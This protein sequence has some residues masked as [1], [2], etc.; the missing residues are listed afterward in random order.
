MSQVTTRLTEGEMRRF[1][2]YRESNGFDSNA[3]AA[4]ALIMLALDTVA[5]CNSEPEPQDRITPL[6]KQ[7]AAVSS[8][9]EELRSQM[10]AIT[11]KPDD[12]PTIEQLKA[13]YDLKPASQIQKPQKPA[14]K[15]NNGTEAEKPFDWSQVSDEWLISNLYDFWRAMVERAIKYIQTLQQQKGKY[16]DPDGNP[17]D[18]ED[19]EQEACNVAIKKIHKEGAKLYQEWQQSLSKAI[20][21]WSNDYLT[22]KQNVG[23]DD[24]LVPDHKAYIENYMLMLKMDWNHVEIQQWISSAQEIEPFDFDPDKPLKSLPDWIVLKLSYDL[25]NAIARR[26]NATT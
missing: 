3:L 2:E 23:N 5:S 22:W 25:D 14:I 21:Q 26:G 16:K 1:L 11:Q 10:R 12:V 9:I 4:H 13:A 8:A 18:G 19:L 24:F 17:I 7:V 6:E 20:L 15:G